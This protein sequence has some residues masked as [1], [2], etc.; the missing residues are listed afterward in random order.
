MREQILRNQQELEAIG[1]RPVPFIS[2]P[3]GGEHAVGKREATTCAEL[4]L[5]IGFTMERSLNTSLEDPLLL[6]RVDTNDALGGKQPMMSVRDGSLQ[7][8]D[9]LG[10]RRKRYLDEPQEIGV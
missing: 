7:I 10:A 8:A 6:A 3:Y 5:R 2:Y 1:G 4:G 9:G